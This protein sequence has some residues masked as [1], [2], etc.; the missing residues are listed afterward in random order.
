MNS[1][2]LST[3][4]PHFS[5][6][7][8]FFFPKSNTPGCTLES[9][10]F[11]ALLPEFHKLGVEIVGVSRDTGALQQKFCDKNNLSIKM[12]SDTDENLHRFFAVMGIK[13]SF[14]IKRE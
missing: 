13:K 6:T 2:L 3:L 5:K 10:D 1:L 11:S 9:R 12:V 4:S 14:G 8:I 7:L